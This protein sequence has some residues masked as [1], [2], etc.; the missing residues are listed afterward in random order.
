MLYLKEYD[1]KTLIIFFESFSRN[2]SLRLNLDNLQPPGLKF[3]E[4]EQLVVENDSPIK[5]PQ[6]FRELGICIEGLQKKKKDDI[7][8]D[9]W[10]SIF[11]SLTLPNKTEGFIKESIFCTAIAKRL[12]QDLKELTLKTLKE[13]EKEYENFQ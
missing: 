2:L 6:I 8:E 7:M 12:L 13:M 3:F 11:P 9:H 1:K 10:V 5:L 4:F